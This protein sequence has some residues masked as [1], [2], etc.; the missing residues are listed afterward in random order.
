MINNNDPWW[1]HAKIYELYIDKF[2]GN[3]QGL[4]ARLPY[5]KELGVNTLHLLPFYPSPMVDQGYDIT[6]YRSVRPELGTLDDLHA[7]IT[8]AHELDLR[9]VV[10]FVINHVSDQHPWFLEARA[11][12]ENPKRNFFLWSD[13]P[14]RFTQGINAFT[15]I[16]QGNWIWNE[17]TKDF[18]YAT[19]Y[20]Q[21]PD[22]NW[23]NE[24]VAHEMFDVVDFL[25]SLGVDGFRVDAAP[26]IIKREGTNCKSLPET[27]AIYKRLR[28]HLDSSYPGVILLAEA[29]DST[30][31]I[32]QYFGKG[33]EFHM[34]YHFPL[35]NSLWETILLGDYSYITA[36]LKES[37]GI[38]PDCQWATFLRNHDDLDVRGLGPDMFYRIIDI[39]DPKQEYVFNHATTTSVR[40]ATA[41]QGDP[42]RILDA[43]KLL[44]SIPGAPVWYYGD[45][46]GMK[47]LPRDTNIVDTRVC[48]RGQF[49][50]GE[51]ERQTADSQ[52]LYSQIRNI[53]SHS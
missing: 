37:E 14:N 41:L 25:V 46:I 19:F 4:R 11:S 48:V 50:W 40:L 32:K 26:H 5:F 43:A 10:D 13:S 30:N 9:I 36:T 20:P 18:Y 8:A 47:N 33:D 22:L 27:H 16:K 42:Q 44:Y 31:G 23:D 24:E 29:G 53:V 28:A 21:Q 49:D 6:D 35:M 38:P 2:S 12:R 7:C 45:E 3:L 15:D 17:P 52:S 1:L 51:A 39:I 34:A